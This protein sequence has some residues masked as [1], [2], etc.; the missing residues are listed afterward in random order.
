MRRLT[1][2]VEIA[3]YTINHTIDYILEGIYKAKPDVLCFSCYIWNLDYVEQLM[4]EYHQIC[5]EVPIWVG[6][7]E[8]SYETEAFLKEHPQVTGVMTGEGEET[9]LELCESY[10]KAGIGE[11]AEKMNLSGIK[12]IMCRREPCKNRSA[13][14]AGF[15]P[16]SVLLW[17][18]RRFPEPHHLL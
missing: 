3:E 11:M 13:R 2:P 7:P 4:D 14:A 16:D 17:R 6:G 18:R 5:P 1:V 10:A 9:F 12:G 8:V 15:K